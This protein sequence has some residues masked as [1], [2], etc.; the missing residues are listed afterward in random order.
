LTRSWLGISLAVCCRGLAVA[1]CSVSPLPPTETPPQ[2][3]A[4]FVHDTVSKS[5]LP[6]TFV[7]PLGSAAFSQYVVK[8]A[9]Y[10]S[11]G[12]AL[13]YHYG[14]SLL[15]SVKG[16]FVCDFGFPV[17]FKQNPHYSRLSGSCTAGQRALHVLK[18][19]V[20]ID[21]GKL[22]WSSLPASAA[23]AGLSDAYVPDPQ[24]TWSAT[25]TRIGTNVAGHIVGEAYEEFCPSIQHVVKF[26]PCPSKLAVPVAQK[27]DVF[28]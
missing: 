5:S 15:D 26:L 14:V 7:A 23:L 21:N 28:K 3:F 22:N 13:A 10:G 18:S 20:L 24:K 19:A 27:R 12:G 6:S 25:L 16:K 2:H 17:L 9:G 1:Q 8:P 4:D 11:G